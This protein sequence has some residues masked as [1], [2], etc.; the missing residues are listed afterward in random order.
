MVSFWPKEADRLCEWG[1]VV[2]M[3]SVSTGICWPVAL[4]EKVKSCFVILGSLKNFI[5]DHLS[6][7]QQ[8]P[9]VVWRLY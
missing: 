4:V 6:K 8:V 7:M 1:V 2:V 5:G 3:Q 9:F